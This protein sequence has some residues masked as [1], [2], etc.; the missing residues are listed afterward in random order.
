MNIK[1][2]L[3]SGCNH[4]ALDLISQMLQF[5]PDDRLILF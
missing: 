2:I 1:I 4:D 5:H 3:K